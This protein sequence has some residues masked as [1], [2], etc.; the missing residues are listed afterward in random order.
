MPEVARLGDPISCGD[1]LAEGSGD[2]FAEGM[3]V[4]RVTTDHTAGHCFAPT[5]I[6]SGSGT[7]FVN[8][9]PVARLGDP[10]NSGIHLCAG[11]PHPGPPATIASAAG[12][13]YADS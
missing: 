5:V 10:I 3:P 8:N 4:T 9:D 13:V 11:Y 12:T 6:A 2:V 1:V 7:V